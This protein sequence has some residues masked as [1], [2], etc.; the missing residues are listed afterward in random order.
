MG[1]QWYLELNTKLETIGF[2]RL[3]SDWS[4]YTP[5]QGSECSYI[6]TSVDDMLIASTSDEESDAVVDSIASLFEITDN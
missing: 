4:V 5:T 3:E 6:T 2:R 1:R